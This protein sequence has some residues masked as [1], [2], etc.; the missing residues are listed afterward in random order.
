MN[1]LDRLH[2]LH[3]TQRQKAW[4]RMAALECDLLKEKKH[5]RII[6]KNEFK[7]R[8]MR[9]LGMIVW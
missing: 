4:R 9:D 6:G 7:F 1:K 3:E 5:R 2:K 8:L